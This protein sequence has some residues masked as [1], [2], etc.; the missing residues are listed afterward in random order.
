MHGAAPSTSP[1]PRLGR[2]EAAQAFQDSGVEWQ[3][4]DRLG[5]VAR[6][7]LPAFVRSRSRNP[8]TR[9]PRWAEPPNAAVL[10]PIVLAGSW[11]DRP[12]DQE[13]L[14]ELAGKSWPELEPLL[15]DAAKA[16]D[17]LFRHAG[18]HWTLSHPEEAFLVLSDSL[19]S[20]A[21]KRWETVAQRAILDPDPFFGMDDKERLAAQMRGV[22]LRYSHSLRRGLA[23][24]LAMFGAMGSTSLMSTSAPADRIVRTLL[25][26]ACS[27]ATGAH[28]FE[29]SD[30]LS[31]LAEA[32]PDAF[33][34][35]LEEDLAQEAP[36]SAHLFAPSRG[37]LTLGPSTRHA[38]LLWALETICWS[39]EYLIRGAQV[40][41]RLDRFRASREHWQP[42]HGE[43]RIDFVWLGYAH[44]RR[45][46]IS[47]HS[48]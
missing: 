17:P 20:A 46:P 1:S 9:R 34:S 40:L 4:A 47:P 27:D 10:A 11:E 41:A 36:T 22:E 43:S 42:A 31:F 24:G 25:A 30:V 19:S 44:E 23:Q 35:A 14:A 26:E 3:Q 28:W 38:N 15:A 45:S 7:S 13:L 33:L 37:N 21:I 32:A 8:R 48:H 2:A 39:E 29:L 16:P 18:E 12:S 6:R 5:A